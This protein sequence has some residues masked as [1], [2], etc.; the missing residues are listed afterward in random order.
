MDPN[1]EIIVR[2][3][4]GFPNNAALLSGKLV[5]VFE[6]GSPAD[7]EHGVYIHHILVADVGKTTFPFA[8]CPDTQVKKYVGPWT[9]SF[10]LDAVGAGFIQVGNDAV[11][12][13]NIYAARGKDSSIKSAFMTGFN[14]MFLMEA[15]IVNY[16]PDNQT[17]YIN[18]ELEYLPE[19]PEGYLDASTVIFSATGCNNPGYK[20]PNQNPQY[21]H[22][23][24]DFVMKQ[25]GTIVNMR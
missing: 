13:A 25:D 5:T 2:T 3:L 18:A 22:T 9:A 15:E 23:S 8:L 11:N 24:E 6:D 1:S 7:Y 21:N 14:D 16:R 17:V 20:P 19:K 10:V 4:K 12:G